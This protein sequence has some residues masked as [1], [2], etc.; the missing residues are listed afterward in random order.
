MR[1]ANTAGAIVASRLACADAMPTLDEVEAL[2]TPGSRRP[3]VR[4]DQL[5]QLIATRVHRPGAVAEAA[6]PDA[7]PARCSASTAS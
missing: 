4:D 3:S 2:M 6:P 7:G 5:S 1:F